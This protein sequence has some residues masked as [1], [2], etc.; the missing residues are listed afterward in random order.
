MDIKEL[1][2]IMTELVHAKG[3]DNL[4]STKRP[5]TLRNLAIS[6]SLEANEVLELF[7]WSDELN[8]KDALGD[9]LA[10]VALYLLQLAQV[11]GIDLEQAILSKV[12]RNHERTWD[13]PDEEGQA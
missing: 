9:E 4:L 1:T 7:Q 3:W 11:G 13:E 5:Q 12:N 8:D 6:L 10:D 2:Q